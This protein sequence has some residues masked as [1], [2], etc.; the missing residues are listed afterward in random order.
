M[1]PRCSL[2][3]IWWA[4]PIS[5]I[6]YHSNKATRPLPTRLRY[7]CDITNWYSKY[8]LVPPNPKS[9]SVPINSLLKEDRGGTRRYW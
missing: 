4:T 2:P 5:N 3:D 1:D 6:T 9:S 8:Q 7:F